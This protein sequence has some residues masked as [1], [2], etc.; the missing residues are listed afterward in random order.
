MIL[1]VGCG[2]RKVEAAAIGIDVSPRSGADIIWD[3]NQ[4]PWPLESDKFERVHMSH[5]IEH[6]QES[7][8]TIEEIHR[9]ARDGAEVLVVTP[10]FSSHNSYTDPTHRWH[11]AARS[12]E[13]FS[14]ADFASFTGS[15]VAFDVSQV[16]LTFGGNFVL[17]GLGRWLARRNIEW[18]ERHAAWWFPALDIQCRLKVRKSSSNP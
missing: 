14:G 2:T 4:F 17:D 13:Y 11:L 3:L 9:V 10:H 12:F 8:R 5:I 7:P 1:D 18:Y 15:R 6:V 16:E